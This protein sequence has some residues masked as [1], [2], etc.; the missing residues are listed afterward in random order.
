MQSPLL[1]VIQN[2]K[3]ETKAKALTAYA[4]LLPI[5]FKLCQ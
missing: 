2:W 1:T 4:Y 5:L 3:S